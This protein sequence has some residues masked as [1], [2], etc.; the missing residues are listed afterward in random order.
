[1][2]NGGLSI[3]FLR[4]FNS[5]LLCKWLWHYGLENDDLGRRVI[6]VKYGN[7]GGWFT[8]SIFGAYGICMWKFIRSGWLN[9][10]N[11]LWYN[12]GDGT[13]VKFWE[14]IWCWGHPLKEAFPDLYNT[15]R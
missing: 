14:D 8:K 10:S 5:A 13:Q 3:R 15:S 2:K 4:R 6:E 12:V 1:M 9:F 11:F 7:G